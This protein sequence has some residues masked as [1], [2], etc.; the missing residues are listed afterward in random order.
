MQTQLLE[1]KTGN[2]GNCFG[3]IAM[4]GLGVV[5]PVANRGRLHR[6]ASHTVE[7]DFATKHR[8]DENAEAVG[9]ASRALA[10]AHHTAPLE[11]FGVVGRVDSSGWAQWFPIG[12]PATIANAHLAEGRK[13]VGCERAQH[14]AAPMQTQRTA[15]PSRVHDTLF[16]TLISALTR[17][18]RRFHAVPVEVVPA[19]ISATRPSSKLWVLTMMWSR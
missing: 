17:C 11:C 18:G 1:S 16:S 8:V 13:V 19:R 7:V 15:Q 14:H 2:D 4:P 9:V 10:F 5:N 6:T 12:E 3:H